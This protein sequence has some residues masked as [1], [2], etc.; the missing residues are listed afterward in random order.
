VKLRQMRLRQKLRR[1]A[2]IATVALFPVTLYYF[3]P[4]LSLAGLASGVVTGSIVVFALLFVSSLFLGRAF[5]GWACPAGGVQEV[6][7]GFKGRAVKRLSIRWVKWLIWAPW[8]LALLLAT[9]KAGGV[10]SIDFTWQTWHGISVADMPGLIALVS[11]A[12]LFSV[13]ALAVGRRAGCHTVCWIAPFMILGRKIRNMFAW[14][15]LRL[16][17]R[18]ESCTQ[19]ATCARGCPMSIEV[20]AMVKSGH[21]ESSDC[22]LC[23]S[24]VDACPQG[25]LRITFSSGH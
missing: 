9:F 16:L 4:F 13:L 14:P 22:I 17:A 1:A 21:M 18:A 25:T 12:G 23:A 11:V 15:S 3:S 10:H 7:R 6:V 24:C 2:T 8:V 5:C 19:C 20:S